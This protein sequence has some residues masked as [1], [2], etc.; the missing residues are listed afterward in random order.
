MNATRHLGQAHRHTAVER[1][2]VSQRNGIPFHVV[3]R[4]CSSCQAVLAER[5]VRRFAA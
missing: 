4:V 5:P 3:R 1:P 2:A